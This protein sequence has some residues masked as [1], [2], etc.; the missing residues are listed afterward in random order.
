VKRSQGKIIV[1]VA[2]SGAGKSTLI[3]RIKEDFPKLEESISCTTR[4]PRLQERNG[5]H[6]HFIT[7]E[8]FELKKEQNDFLEWAKVHG[9]FYGTS[10]TFVEQKL[11]AGID[12]LFDLDV[13]GADSFKT[14]FKGRENIIFIEP[15]SLDILEKRL[16]GRATESEEVIQRRL[17]NAQAEILKKNEYNY[18]IKNDDLERAHIELK[19][20]IQKILEE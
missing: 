8:D 16:R 9:N 19:G 1:I 11:D 6:Y 15:P 2:P 17:K 14:Y 20:L 5:V 4:A 3:K 13:Q 18:C 7:L 12:L 10:K